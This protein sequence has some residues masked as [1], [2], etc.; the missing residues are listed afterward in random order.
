MKKI[1]LIVVFI[2][3]YQS[4]TQNFPRITLEDKSSL[5]LDQLYINAEISG[6]YATISYDMTF[7]NGLD[8]VLEG[9]LAFPLAQGQSV[10]QFAMDLNGKLRSAVVVEKELGRVA[11]E[12][13][14]KQRIDPA[15][16]EQTQG[17][18]YKARVY[19]IPAKGYKRIVIS[20]EQNLLVN[21]G[22]YQFKIPF[23][24]EKPLNNFKIEIKCNNQIIRPVI[25][26][27]FQDDLK[28]SKSDNSVI[29]KF[30]GQFIDLKRNLALEIAVKDVFS[31]STFDD[32]FHVSKT[33]VPK[34]RLKVKPK[35]LTI[36][37][38][39][40]Y[41]MQYK[42]L[43]EELDLL[44]NY[45]KYLGDVKVNVITF[46]NV[47]ISNETYKI[48]DGI[49]DDLKATLKQT[50]YDGGTSYKNLRIPKSDEILLFSDGLHN[51]G[52]IDFIKDTKLYCINSVS[53][54]NHQLL[55]VLS[56]EQGGNYINLNSISAKSS[57]GLLKY[58][59]FEFLGAK[60]KN[61]LF[62]IYPE[63]HTVVNENFNINGKYV[64]DLSIELLFGY[65]DEITERIKVDMSSSTNS[66]ITKRLWAKAKLKHLIKRKEDNK[67]KI[68]KLAKTYHLISPYTSLIVLDRI[69]DYVRYKIEPPYELLEEYTQKLSQSKANQLDLLENIRERKEDLQSDHKDLRDWYDKDFI[70]KRERKTKR[71]RNPKIVSRPVLEENINTVSNTNNTNNT[72]QT[73][74]TTTIVSRA[75]D[76]T[77]PT[78]YGTV[79]TS[80]DGLPLPG[81]NVLIK[82][83]NRGV[84]TDFNGDFAINALPNETLN[85]SF[86][87][88][89]S[90]DY[91][92]NAQ[93]TVSIVLS[94]GANSLD[95]VIVMGY[96]TMSKASYSKSTV[97]VSAETIEDRPNASFVQTLSGQVSGV[98]I[99]SSAGQPGSNAFVKLLGV[100]AINGNTGPLF[101]VDG[102]VVS[103]DNFRSLKPEEI[104]AIEI[105]KETAATAIYGSR[106]AN[107][108]VI[109]TTKNSPKENKEAID[110]LNKKITEQSTL[111]PWSE[112]ASYLEY[113]REQ[114]SVEEAYDAY[115]KMRQTYRNTPSF[116]LDIADFFE[117][118]NRIDIALRIATNL[119]EIELDNHELIRALAYKLEQYNKYDL[120]IYV[121]KAV[122]ELR[123]EHPQAHRDLALA[124]EA[125]GDFDAAIDMFLNIING[126]LLHKDENEMFYGIEQVAYVELCHL[127]NSVKGKNL[128]DLREIYKPI[129]TDLRVVVDWNHGETDLDMYVTS[130]DNEVVYYGHDTSKHGGR[131]S[132][133]MT[134]GYGPESFWIRKAP[135]GAYKISVD[136]YS[137]RIQ[138]ITGPASL[139]VTI[140]RNYGKPNEEKEIKVLRL[141]DNDSKKEVET[142]TL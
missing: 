53:S 130:P 90:R 100:S 38:D 80:S 20:Y 4:Y 88:M 42:R 98:N 69:E 16:L 62:E 79:T 119:I 72:S 136:Y 91:S 104:Q 63:P 14:I 29:G 70:I 128:K 61:T 124:Y 44:T 95:E 48:K 83:T 126:D 135:K 6:N 59:A 34:S 33:F 66:I 140:F 78:V 25:N 36:L 8:R 132:E 134:E 74:T 5:T 131:L 2:A 99:T 111:K 50:R 85:I 84:T 118:K 120:A 28:F 30:E 75:V 81:A 35:S 41:S 110:T 51:L 52:T 46:S 17:N 92:L 37:W 13:T 21:N 58:E 18:N 54:A 139:K 24:F 116:F 97:R 1:I 141:S 114:N 7:Y 133:D 60:H 93:T 129:K 55:E 123:P 113:I 56:S 68:I 39:A 32:Y 26:K 105:I 127:V 109:I 22:N 103:E 86:I 102:M 87:G 73:K 121:Y 115:L 43:D 82:G 137:D 40:S 67:T 71:V 101:V 125:N 89:I 57:I 122:L 45:L 64:Q 96:S 23:G 117:T 12:T 11:Y 3:S 107:G 94:E 27:E 138:K 19:P 31:I 9:E 47:V 76:K 112:T 65:G 49:V 15:L 106:G 77:K 142:I 108:V 10:S